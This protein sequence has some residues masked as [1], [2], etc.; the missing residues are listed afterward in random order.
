MP[1]ICEVM[2]CKCGVDED[3][4]SAAGDGRTRKACLVNL[5]PP[6][7]AAT[8]DVDVSRQFVSF[9]CYEIVMETPAVADCG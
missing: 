2:P 9:Y 7:F 8:T 5:K 6:S 4:P 1:F 3:A